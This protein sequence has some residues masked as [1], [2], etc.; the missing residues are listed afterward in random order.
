[1]DLD[2]IKNDKICVVGESGCWIWMGGRNGGG[3]GVV[4]H[5]GIVW[6]VHRLA[7]HLRGYE[8]KGKAVCHKCDT[9]LC[10]NPDHLFVGTW[11]DNN[12]DRE[13]KGRGR[14]P[15]GSRHGMAKISEEIARNIF[16]DKIS[17]V[18]AAQKYGV[19]VH[20]VSNIRTKKQWSKATQGLDAPDYD[21]APKTR[22]NLRQR[23]DA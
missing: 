16:L 8:I 2:P 9:P 22:K 4:R 17:G 3:Y 18:D 12:R 11:G 21:V 1:M 14:Q 13:R 15:H 6:S 20:T 23:A 5:G 19:S 10:V 7:M